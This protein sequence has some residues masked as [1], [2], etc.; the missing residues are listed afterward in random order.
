MKIYIFIIGI[1]FLLCGC[2]KEIDSFEGESGI[3]FEVKNIL[4]DTIEVPW[5][6]KPTELKSQTI[7]LRVLLFGDVKDYDRK[8][9]VEVKDADGDTLAAVAGKDYKEFS[10][11]YVIPAFKAYTDISIELLRDKV[12][13][14][15]PRRFTVVLQEGEELGFPYTRVHVGE[16]SVVRRLD[17]QRV[18]KMTEN[19]PRPSWWGT[20]GQKYFGDWSMTK[21]ITICDEMEIDREVWLTVP[22]TDEKFTSGYL[23]YCGVYMHRWLQKQDPP[24]LDWNDEPMEMGEESKY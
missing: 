14:E 7:K 5:G 15:E 23:K 13:Q 4:L 10:K 11:E 22:N 12:L 20:Y 2:E 3:Y 1:L 18:I 17:L 8:F 6:L 19:F 21:A 24:V 9:S 16:D